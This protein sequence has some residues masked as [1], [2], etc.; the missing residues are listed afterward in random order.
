MPSLEQP[1]RSRLCSSSTALSILPMGSME[2]ALINRQRISRQFGRC[3]ATYDQAAIAQQRIAAHSAQI[4]AEFTRS[5]PFFPEHAL[6]IGCGTGGLTRHLQLLFPDTNWILNDIQGDCATQALAFCSSPTTFV[7]ADIEHW[8]WKGTADLI[9]STSVFQWIAHPAAFVTRLASWQSPNS[10]LMFSTFL[11]GNLSEIHHLA[12]QG[13]AYP[14]ASQWQH[15]LAPF[16]NL[17]ILE[18]E[19]IQLTFDT[20]NQVLHHLRQ[21]G[22]TATH[23]QIWTPHRLRQFMSQYRQ[24][25]STPQGQ[26]SLTYRPLY[27]LAT[28]SQH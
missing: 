2:P 27:I 3:C 14:S 15:W 11:P 19:T 1:R 7:Q 6:E 20:P 22:V 8:E 4:L 13:L 25:F 24:L 5:R 10:I 9:A 17:Q 12:H 16:Y 23:T 28:R 18:D 21:T 26:V